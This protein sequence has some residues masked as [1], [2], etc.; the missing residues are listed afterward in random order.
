MKSLCFVSFLWLTLSVSAQQPPP[1]KAAEPSRPSPAVSNR[2]VEI[3]GGKAWLI[4]DGKT[5][6]LKNEIV[7]GTSRVAPDGNMQ[8]KDGKRIKL[9]NGDK[10]N[11]HGALEQGADKLN[12]PARL[13]V[14]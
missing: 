8:T 2:S 1:Q 6:L 7:L 14:E 9:K 11:E 4:V 5:T 3:S 13:R 10:V 12:E